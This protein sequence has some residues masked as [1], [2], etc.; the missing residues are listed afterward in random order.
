MATFDN[1]SFHSG[2]VSHWN[3]LL[4]YLESIRVCI[5]EMDL[6]SMADKGVLANTALAD[7]NVF[8]HMTNT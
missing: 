4:A 2:L 3:A 6:K 8:K 7:L 1:R 5:V